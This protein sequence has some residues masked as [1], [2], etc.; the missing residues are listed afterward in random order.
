MHQQLSIPILQISLIEK[1]NLNSHRQ[2]LIDSRLKPRS[3][4][5]LSNILST[6]LP[7]RQRTVGFQREISVA[8]DELCAYEQL[9]I[10]RGSESLTLRKEAFLLLFLYA[11]N[12]FTILS[13]P[14]FNQRS[15]L[16]LP[17][18]SPLRIRN[19]VILMVGLFLGMTVVILGVSST[20]CF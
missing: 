2:Q 15:P 5:S 6:A 10:E 3:P 16:I 14:F 11:I 8:R 4:D 18:L 1:N 13:F 20:P 9:A 17:G 12:Y 7:C 19:G